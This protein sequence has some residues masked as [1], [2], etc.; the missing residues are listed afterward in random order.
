MSRYAS[1]ST[2]R[3]SSSVSSGFSTYAAV[4][5]SRGKRRSVSPVVSDNLPRPHHCPMQHPTPPPVVSGSARRA[6][7]NFKYSARSQTMRPSWIV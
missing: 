7:G 2:A 3:R 4:P 6:N 5:V 1:A